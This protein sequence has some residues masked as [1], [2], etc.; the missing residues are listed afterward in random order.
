MVGFQQLWES[1]KLSCF[2]SITSFQTNIVFILGINHTNP[3]LKLIG[4]ESGIL[5]HESGLKKSEGIINH[6]I[7]QTVNHESWTNNK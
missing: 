5:N 7:S 6:I 2:H 3:G 1:N 4:G